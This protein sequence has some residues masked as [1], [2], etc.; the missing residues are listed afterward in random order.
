LARRSGRTLS[1]CGA[2]LRDLGAFSAKASELM[3]VPIGRMDLSLVHSIE[4][5]KKI[6]EAELDPGDIQPDEVRVR[7]T[8]TEDEL[9]EL[10][11][12]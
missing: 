4:H 9:A 8:M 5:R 2:F 3:C 10:F 1:W 12:A 6:R 11:G 7:E